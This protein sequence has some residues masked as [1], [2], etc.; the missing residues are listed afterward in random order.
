MGQGQ[1]E[2][3]ATNSQASICKI[4]KY[5]NSPQILQRCKHKIMLQDIVVHILARARKGLQ[6]RIP[7][8]KSHIGF[9]GNEEADKLATAATDPGLSFSRICSRS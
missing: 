4:A 3:I 9:Q 7:K 6:T 2:I 8:V 5:T 1:D